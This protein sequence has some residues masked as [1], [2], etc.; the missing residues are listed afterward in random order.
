VLG[1][2]DIEE[3]VVVVIVEKNVVVAVVVVGKKKRKRYER[4]R[5]DFRARIRKETW[6]VSWQL[7]IEGRG[8]WRI[9]TEGTGY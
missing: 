7:V 8:A 3:N 4:R 6:E 5:N 2:Q 9:R 1:H